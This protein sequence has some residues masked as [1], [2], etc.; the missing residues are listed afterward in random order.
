DRTGLDP[1]FIRAV[2]RGETSPAL[3]PLVRI[4]RALGV[5]LGTFMDDQVSQDPCITK[6]GDQG[7]E[8]AV[9]AS[10]VKSAAMTYHHLGSGKADRHMEPMFIRLD[11]EGQSPQMSSHE[12]EEFVIVVSGEVVLRY[13]E[14]VHVLGAGDSLY[15][16]SIVP[17]HLGAKGPNPAEIYAVIYVPF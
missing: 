16:N 8:T 10:G 14:Q 11:P 1:S 13:G 2:E 7:P 9:Q 6:A 3:G 12:G 5:R 15:Y 17:H 4:S